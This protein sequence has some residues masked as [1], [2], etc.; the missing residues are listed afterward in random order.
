VWGKGQL[1]KPLDDGSVHPRSILSII[2]RPHLWN[3]NYS[4]PASACRPR[5]ATCALPNRL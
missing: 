3:T 4:N 1:Q 2:I 5:P